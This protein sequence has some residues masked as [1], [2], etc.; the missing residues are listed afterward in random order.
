MDVIGVIPARFSSTRFEGKVLAKIYGK[1]LVQYVYENARRAKLLDDLVVATDDQR[2]VEAVEE[3]GGK[4]ILTAKEHRSGSDRL[5]EVVSPIDVKVVVNIQGDEPLIQPTMIDE[6][7]RTLLDQ[8]TIPGGTRIEM[9]TI[10]K[11]IEVQEEISNPD[12]VKVVF[13]KDGFALYFSRS[14][15]PYKSEGKQIVNHYKHIGLY[16]YS[17]DFLFKFSNFAVSDLEKAEKLEQLRA[18]ENGCRIKVIETDYETISVDTRED[19][20][21]VKKR[22]RIEN[23]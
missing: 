20:E 4:A 5:K 9:A 14:P 23:A 19:L 6:L 18:L 2:V 7:A 15:I 12:V 10:V 1:P 16:A 8:P 21:R 3:F 13:D 17:K 22:L 11:K